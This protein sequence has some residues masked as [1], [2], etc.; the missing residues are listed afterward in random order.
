MRANLITVHF[1]LRS[2]LLM[3]FK[4]IFVFKIAVGF[5]EAKNIKRLQLNYYRV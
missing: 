5:N 1:D 2:H 4:S 3:R